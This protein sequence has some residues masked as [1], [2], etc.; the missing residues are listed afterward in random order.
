MPLRASESGTLQKEKVYNCTAKFRKYLKRKS[1]MSS[2]VVRLVSGTQRIDTVAQNPV[3]PL[4]GIRRCVEPCGSFHAY[5][6]P[7]IG[8]YEHRWRGFNQGRS[9]IAVS[10]S[11]SSARFVEGPKID[12]FSRDSHV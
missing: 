7:N 6:A 10:D 5:A 9:N 8:D 2:G 3:Q 1:A 11:N 12:D 4:C